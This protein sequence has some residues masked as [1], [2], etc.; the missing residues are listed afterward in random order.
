ML[1][2]VKLN[3]CI[4]VTHGK[5]TALFMRTAGIIL[6]KHQP[7]VVSTEDR[8]AN[9]T[10]RWTKCSACIILQVNVE[11]SAASLRTIDESQ[12]IGHVPPS[13]AD[14]SKVIWTP[15]GLSWRYILRQILQ[16]TAND[17]LRLTLINS[18]LYTTATMLQYA[19]V[20]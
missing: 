13:N 4:P 17:K 16:Q 2:D 1:S 8:V 18:Q 19:D 12:T 11:Q 9:G 15:D 7:C 3:N 10:I 6:Q 20:N 14:H 5:S